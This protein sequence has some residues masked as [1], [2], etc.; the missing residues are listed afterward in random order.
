MLGESNGARHRCDNRS[1]LDMNTVPFL[2]LLKK[3]DQMVHTERHEDERQ[4][5]EAPNEDRFKVAK[6]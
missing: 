6:R 1:I 2:F 3:R 5:Y 4:D